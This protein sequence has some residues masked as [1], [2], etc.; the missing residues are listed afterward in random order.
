MEKHHKSAATQAQYLQKGHTLHEYKEKISHVVDWTLQEKRPA[1]ERTMIVTVASPARNGWSMMVS[2][3]RACVWGTE[4]SAKSASD[5]REAAR[6]RTSDVMKKRTYCG[7][8]SGVTNCIRVASS[9]SSLSS[10]ESY[11]DRLAISP[12]S[13]HFAKKKKK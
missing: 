1:F 8:W 11:N 6:S 13:K 5:T 4:V 2:S 7:S 3:M 10:V 12:Y 9:C